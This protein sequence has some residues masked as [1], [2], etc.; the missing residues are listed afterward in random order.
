M[1][2]L[3]AVAAAVVM[4]YNKTFDR[5][6]NHILCPTAAKPCTLPL[7]LPFM[8]KVKVQCARGNAQPCYFRRTLGT[9]LTTYCIVFYAL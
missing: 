5:H 6:V 9:K 4:V 2:E 7:I 1:E 8:V 3:L